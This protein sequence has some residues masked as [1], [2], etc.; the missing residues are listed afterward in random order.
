M[1]GRTEKDTPGFCRAELLCTDITSDRQGATTTGVVA[2]VH[3]FRELAVSR[4][5]ARERQRRNSRGAPLALTKQMR[6][7][8]FPTPYRVLPALQSLFDHYHFLR[9]D[10]TPRSQA[11]IVHAARKRRRIEDGLVS[12]GILLLI[13]KYRD[14]ASDHI[15]HFH[16]NPRLLGNVVDDVRR[17]V[18]R[19]RVVL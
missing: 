18:E 6:P 7:R 2:S 10:K 4:K 8:F 13:D 3:G 16:R 17:R 11:V 9:V 19:V 5:R 1:F 14:L 12:A 15:K